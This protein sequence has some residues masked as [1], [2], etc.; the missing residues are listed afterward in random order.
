[1]SKNLQ[2]LF[3]VLALLIASTLSSCKSNFEKLR[4]SN[5]IGLK[6]QEAIKY[7]ENKKYSKALV[8]FD[9]LNQRYRGQ[10]EAEDLLFYLAYT[11]YRLKDYTTARYHFGQ[12]ASS[13]PYSP[14]AEEARFMAAYCYYEEAPRYSLDQEYTLRALESLQ[15][16]LNLYPESTRVEEAEKL[17]EDLRDRLEYKAFQNAKLY[18]DMGLMDDYRAAVIAFESALRDYPD[19]KY[20][21]EMEFLQMKAQYLY[22]SNSTFRRQEE[23]FNEVLD[24]YSRFS[25]NYPESKFL[26]EATEIKN[27]AERGI[28]SAKKR[29]KE[30]D[31]ALAEAASRN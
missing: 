12:F 17:I 26:K 1:M 9:D 29:I 22:G 18:L 6:Y 19:S 14:R 27:D 15:L 5:N 24:M 4:T 8:L 2:K 3:V 31:E 10:A 23:R 16:F 11:N 7:Y 20:S 25:V 28:E 30:M 13:Y 21:E